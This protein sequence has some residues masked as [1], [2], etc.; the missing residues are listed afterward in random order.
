M[1]PKEDL[2]GAQALADKKKDVMDEDILALV[3]DEV[4]QPEKLW[5]VLD[6]QVG[7]N[8]TSAT[9]ALGCWALD[10]RPMLHACAACLLPRQPS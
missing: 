8:F 4:H 2:A 7:S 9:D 5:D 10:C 6:L 1:L 3:S